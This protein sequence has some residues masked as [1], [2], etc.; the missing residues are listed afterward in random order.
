MHLDVNGKRPYLMRALKFQ[1][2]RCELFTLQ[3]NGEAVLIISQAKAVEQQA[4]MFPSS[5][6]HLKCIQIGKPS[7]ITQDNFWCTT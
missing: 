5:M 7:I 6:S 2:S 3:L 4:L 1:S